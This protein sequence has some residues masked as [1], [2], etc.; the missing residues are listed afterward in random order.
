MAHR[1][2]VPL[3]LLA[4]LALLTLALAL[5]GA[6]AA[7]SGATVSVQNAST[8]TFGSPTGS[9]S[10]TMHVVSSLGA[11][12]GTPKTVQ[13]NLVTYKPPDHMAIYRV[14][15]SHAKF[16]GLMPPAAAA[17]DL[18]VYTS[19]VGGSTAWTS[20]GAGNVYERTETLADYSNRVPSASSSS[21]Q[22]IPTTAQGQ[23]H[24]RAVVRGGYLTDLRLHA[25]VPAQT[26]PSGRAAPSGDESLTLLL[27]EINGTHTFGS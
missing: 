5:L 3:T 4:V 12:A 23:V 22:P 17:C 21:C 14:Q 6:S 7:P 26:L 13:V 16:L 18:S 11:G 9:T 8:T 20:T 10:F 1:N 2:F 25:V 24:E 15:G 27:N 19:Y